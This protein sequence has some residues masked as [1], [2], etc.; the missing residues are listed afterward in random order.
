MVFYIDRIYT[1]PNIYY[2]YL[3]KCKITRIPLPVT[4]AEHSHDA[5]Y[6]YQNSIYPQNSFNEFNED[7]NGSPDLI[8]KW[9]DQG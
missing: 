3:Q 6:Y 5:C 9:L 7:L 2:I 4:D 1:K 8:H